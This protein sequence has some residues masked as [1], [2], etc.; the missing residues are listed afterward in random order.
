MALW[1]LGVTSFRVPLGPQKP[2]GIQKVSWLKAP[3]T[4]NK[5]QLRQLPAL[6]GDVGDSGLEKE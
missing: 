3:I 5:F 4:I 1:A 2:K 6:S